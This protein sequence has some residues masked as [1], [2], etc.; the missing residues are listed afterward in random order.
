MLRIVPTILAGL[1]L[2]FRVGASE[3]IGLLELVNYHEYS[4]WLASS[5]QPTRDQWPAVAAAGVDLVVNLAPLTDPGSYAEEGDLVRAQ[6]MQYVHIPVDW[7]APPLA[8][9][10]RFLA[11]MEKTRGQRVL[12]HCYANARG[13]AFTYLWRVHKLGHARAAAE[14]DMVRIWD[15]NEGYELRNVPQW[16][17][18]IEAAA[19]RDW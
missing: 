13:S 19:A 9:V 11:V 18:L 16:Q 4:P 7:E 12:V 14:A 10:A 17:A 1:L 15:L 6:G 2:A 8:D 5:G 3:D